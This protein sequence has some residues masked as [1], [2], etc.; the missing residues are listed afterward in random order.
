MKKCLNWLCLLMALMLCL[1]AFALGEEAAPAMKEYGN[2]VFSLSYPEELKLLEG[3]D[4]IGMRKDGSLLFA[5]NWFD[6]EAAVNIRDLQDAGFMAYIVAGLTPPPEGFVD[7]GFVTMGGI[8]Y[9][10]GS[11]R[12]FDEPFRCWFGGAGRYIIFI[13]AYGENGIAAAEETLPSLVP[14]YSRQNA[15]YG[16]EDYL[17]YTCDDFSVP[18]PKTWTVAYEREEEMCFMADDGH[19]FQITWLCF[20]E[21]PDISAEDLF[22]SGAIE[23]MAES[24][25]Q[26]YP[27]AVYTNTGE[28]RSI[29]GEDYA[30][31]SMKHPDANSHQYVIVKG[32]YLLMFSACS[33]EC[34]AQAE[35]II[36]HLVLNE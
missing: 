6:W 24:M 3:P 21:E 31:M 25:L 23:R 13:Y 33:D 10:V 12:V 16:E 34:N 14:A 32:R 7:E 26:Q 28:I 18:Y 15:A 35:Y 8:E 22:T 27:D 9:A 19:L 5:V 2:E 1:P 17:I 30:Y 20:P 11:G 36:S 29:G 4:Y